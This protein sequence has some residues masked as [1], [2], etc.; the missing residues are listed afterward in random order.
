MKKKTRTGVGKSAGVVCAALLTWATTASSEPAE[1]RL[2]GNWQV[3]V[4][5]AVNHSPVSATLDVTRPELT[6]ITDERYEKLRDF[7][8]KA[9]GWTKGNPLTGLRAAECTVNG[10]LDPASLVMREGTEAT[11]IRFDKGTDYDADL[12]WGTVGRLPAGRIKA[13]QPVYI[14]YKYAKRRIDSVVLTADGAIALKQGEP[15][16]A[17]CRQP[18]LSAGETRLATIYIPGMI[19][20]LTTDNLFPILENAYPEPPKSIPTIAEVRLPKTMQ[21][22]R[23]G[24]PLTILAWGD[25]VTTFNR[26]QTMFVERLRARYPAA[27]IEL[28]TEAWG[29]RN[30]GS[31]LAEP[32]GSEHNYKEKVLDRKPDLIVSEFVNDAG[33]SLA[34]VE[35]RYGRLLA[36]FH[37]IGAEWAILT[38]HYV[39]PPLMGLTR[40]RDIDNDPRPYVTGLR[41]FAEKHKV[42]LAD[43]SLRYGRLWRQG[44]PYLTLMENGI[45]H[46]N[47]FGHSLFADSLM[48]LFE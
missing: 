3:T 28:V 9:A 32:P 26:W 19:P 40:Q 31:Y 25:S 16:V 35:E 44:I 37:S 36:D 13:G 17:M 21:K 33:L 2:S 45:N 47:E 18:D 41:Q 34:Q 12:D 30:T 22:L 5:V 8:P 27:R 29:G 23:S 14:S 38:P 15:Q 6:T 20:A 7:N 48:A 24:Q 43:A 42:A 39:F 10:A 4:T 11:A 46:P 1:I